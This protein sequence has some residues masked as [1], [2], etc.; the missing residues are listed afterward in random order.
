MLLLIGGVCAISLQNCFASHHDTGNEESATENEYSSITDKD[1]GEDDDDCGV[2]SDDDTDYVSS[3]V[4]VPI[5]AFVNHLFDYADWW[6]DT[7]CVVNGTA[8]SLIFCRQSNWLQNI[9]QYQ[10]VIRRKMG[11]LTAWGEDSPNECSMFHRLGNQDWACRDN[12]PN[13]HTSWQWQ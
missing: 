11:I 5:P 2:E 9:W 3:Y 6:A 13:L 8:Y 7:V 10:C 1:E 12:H 4:P